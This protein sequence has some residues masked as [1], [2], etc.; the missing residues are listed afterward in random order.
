MLL[1]QKIRFRLPL[2]CS[3]LSVWGLQVQAETSADLQ[4]LLLV[5]LDPYVVVSTRT[6]LSLDRVSPSVAYIDSAEIEFWQDSSLID[7][8]SRETGLAL[9]SLGAKGAQTSLFVRGTNSDHTAIF[10]DGRQLNRGFGN[11]FN[12]DYLTSS[13]LESVQMQ[14]GASSVNYG[15]SGIGGVVDLRSGST[16]QTKGRLIRFEQAFGS[17]DF[18]N[19]VVSAE[20][21]TKDVGIRLS[22][23]RLATDN[24][25]AN[26]RFER[27]TLQARFDYKLSET[28]FVEWIGRYA[29][30][31]KEL[32]G[33][34]VSPNPDHLQKSSDW[35]ISPGIKYATDVLSLHLF[36]SRSEN[37]LDNNNNGAQNDI[38]VETDE[39]HLQAD[40]SAAESLLIS[41]GLTYRN[42]KA[43]NSN[44]AF[45]GPPVAYMDSFE[46][47]G[48]YLQTIW[49][50]NEAI[51]LR[52]GLRYDDYSN[53]ENKTTGSVEGIYSVPG[54]ELS[55]FTKLA[56]SFA[57]PS[58]VDIAFDADPGTT[59]NPEESLSY[60][61]G[62]RQQLSSGDLEYS[63]IFFHNEIDELI[64]FDPNTFDAFNV[65][66]ATTEG[67]EFSVKYAYSTQLDVY[68]GYTYLRA[69]ADQLDDPRT[70]GFPNPAD[71]ASDV[72]LARRAKHQVSFGAQ[73]RPVD[74]LSFGVNAVGYFDREDI[75][76]VS[77]VQEAAEDYF[78][79]NTVIDWDL[80]EHLS[81]YARVENAFDQD[82]ASAAGFPALGR[83][84]YVGASFSF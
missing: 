57:P 68:F 7:T 14:K 75:N 27:E 78:V 35:L 46:Q 54:S 76:P 79:V 45:F 25:R 55:F 71:P 67:V 60:E 53:Y 18:R 28:L 3:V 52:A 32:P 9:I 17:N 12:L 11:Q 81:V 74:S 10:L 38:I 72:P 34:I 23:G 37:N 73:Y 56:S 66:K 31:E 24:A 19:T 61:F 70:P 5:E 77:F 33:S 64:G 63:V 49:N 82:Y 48:A 69:V 30:A 47:L 39:M 8:L 51:E 20:A 50:A 40:Y 22:A 84:S 15:S 58:A 65:Q 41:S 44:V 16:L 42:E 29:Y 4:S 26:D 83:T 2:L 36:Y 59:L 80:S 6:P 1:N 13:Q 62:W 43:F 21:G